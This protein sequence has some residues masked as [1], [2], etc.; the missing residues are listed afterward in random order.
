MDEANKD[1]VVACKL[2]LMHIDN[3]AS[4][5]NDSLAMTEL[6]KAQVVLEKAIRNNGGWK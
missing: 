1:L 5:R 6:V 3:Y 4:S 2:A